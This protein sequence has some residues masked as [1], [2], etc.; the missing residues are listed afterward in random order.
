[1]EKRK[2]LEDLSVGLIFDIINNIQQMVGT[3]TNKRI[4]SNIFKNIFRYI[5]LL[6]SMAG[7]VPKHATVTRTIAMSASLGFSFY[8]AKFQPHNTT[9]AFIYF[10]ISEVL[11]I[12]FIMAVLS[13][14]GYRH[15]FKKKWGN[16]DDGYLVYEAI[17]GFLFFH[18][19]LSLGYVASATAGSFS[20]IDNKEI[21]FII[22]ALPFI[23]GFLIKIFAAKV[24]SID[25]YYWKDMFLG[26]RICDFVVS[27]PY[28]YF[29][30]PMYGIGQLPAYAAA[31]WYGSGYGL[32]AALLNQCLIFTFYY[33]FEKKFIKRIY[34]NNGDNK[35]VIKIL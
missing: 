29:S 34:L 25:I 6:I 32:L 21:L 11:Y 9:F 13:K 24:V 19:A 8:L 14:D 26:K 7:Y 20:V 5:I 3:K 28:K 35:P 31:I 17:L 10:F 15:W 16:E 1:L 12:G 30:N 27:G 18:N 22:V 2:Y 4:D 23:T 33:M